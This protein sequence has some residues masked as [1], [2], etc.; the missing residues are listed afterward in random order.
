MS[1]NRELDTTTDALVDRLDE[2]L[3]RERLQNAREKAKRLVQETE[4]ANTRRA[5]SS[6]LDYFWTW[7]GVALGIS[8]AHYPVPHP[9]LFTFVSEHLNG[10]DETVDRK[11]VALG[12]KQKTG[13]HKLT[14]LRRRLSSLA[15]KHALEAPAYGADHVYHP[16]IKEL[17]RAAGREPQNRRSKKDAITTHELERIFAHLDLT[18]PRGILLRAVLSVGLAS[19]GRRRSELSAIRLEQLTR[20]PQD[21]APGYYFTIA[22]AET[23]THDA[24]EEIP[25]VPVMYEAAKHLQTWLRVSRIVSGPLFRAVRPDGRLSQRMS[26]EWLRLR[27]KE[28]AAVSGLA[29]ERISPHSLRAGFVTQCGRDEIAPQDAMALSLHKSVA[30]FNE[31]YRQ[32]ALKN[33]PAAALMRRKKRGLD[34]S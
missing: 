34:S 22:M 10:L 2:G 13:P 4:R 25:Q 28:L 20:H 8:E 29:V 7:A 33:N 21:E 11:L 1:D 17:L 5:L 30:V 27:M 31:Y 9:V 32:G 26:P 12:V 16:Q 24:A 15:K 23:K 3:I 6:D 14:T 18:H 19:G